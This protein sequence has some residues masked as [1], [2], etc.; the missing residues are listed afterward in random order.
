MS[1]SLQSLLGPNRPAVVDDL[2]GVID[3]QVAAQKGLSGAAVKAAYSAV[4]KVKPDIVTK[5]TNLMLPDFVAALQP[6]WDSRPAGASFGVHLASDPD[7]ASEALLAVTDA[8]VESAKA[9]LAKAYGTLRGK[10]KGYVS[11]A[12]PAVGDVIEKHA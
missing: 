6:F 1:D 3:S 9:P 5:A 7:A 10:A 8:Q 2:V 11:E 4:G 12:L